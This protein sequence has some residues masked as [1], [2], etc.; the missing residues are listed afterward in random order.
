MMRGR[1]SPH[2][3]HARTTLYS[4][5]QTA[6]TNGIEPYLY[7]RYLFTKLPLAK[8]RKECLALG[9]SAP[10]PLTGEI[11]ISRLTFFPSAME[12]SVGFR[13]VAR[14]V[15]RMRAPHHRMRSTRAAVMVDTDRAS[16]RL[17]LDEGLCRSVQ[18]SA[19]DSTVRL[20]REDSD[21]AW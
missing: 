1:G 17:K 21:T 19:Q 6:K 12:W 9:S 3:A 15:V 11:S 7:L 4:L 16:S 5:N 14:L 10:S 13:K 18:K 20:A 8:S 2:G